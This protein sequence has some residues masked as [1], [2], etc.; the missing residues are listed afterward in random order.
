MIRLAVVRGLDPNKAFESEAPIVRIGRADGNDVL[1]S[2]A[3]VSGDHARIDVTDA[4]ARIEDLRSTNGTA[5]LRAGTRLA[6]EA[7]KA[8]DLENGDVVELG[9]GDGAVHLAITLPDEETGAQVLAIRRIDEL[10]PAETNALGDTGR[11]RALYL[12]QKKVGGAAD[13]ADTLDAVADAVLDL[14]PKATHVTLVLKADD[15][16]GAAPASAYVPITTRVR[17]AAQPS[18]AIPISRSVFR[19]VVSERA[20]IMAADAPR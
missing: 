5:I 15:D 20:A 16:D 12:A 13:L 10:A 19:K 11:L 7:G 4:G 9:S 17:G 8:R 6:V 3:I 18:G 14:V 2:D 1:L